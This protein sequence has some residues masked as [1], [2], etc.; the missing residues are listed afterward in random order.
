MRLR[1]QGSGVSGCPSKDWHLYPVPIPYI[2]IYIYIYAYIYTHTYTC[3]IYVKRERELPR[4]AGL[5]GLGASRVH[6]GWVGMCRPTSRLSPNEW[7][8]CSVD[9]FSAETCLRG[10]K[11]ETASRPKAFGGPHSKARGEGRGRGERVRG[12]TGVPRSK[13]NATPPGTA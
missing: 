7:I 6:L 11:A 8:V 10:D 4:C 12:G 13:E 2:Y 5:A 9:A 3:I 1:V